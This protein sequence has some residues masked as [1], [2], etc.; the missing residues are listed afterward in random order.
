LLYLLS[1]PTR[2]SSDLFVDDVNSTL[3]YDKDQAQEYWNKAKEELGVDKLSI[4]LLASDTD[5]SKKT[6]EFLQG[7]LEQNLPD[8]EVNVT[9]RSEEHTSELQSR[10]DL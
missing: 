10:F 9:N 3:S 6:C 4:D 7:S 8:L 1:F 5:Q 2:R